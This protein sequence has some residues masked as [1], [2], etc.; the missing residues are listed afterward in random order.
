[1][2][3]IT[4]YFSKPVTLYV[5]QPYLADRQA[6]Q[7]RLNE[8]VAKPA[9]L[10]DEDGVLNPV[11]TDVDDLNDDYQ[12]RPGQLMAHIAKPHLQSNVLMAVM[13]SL[14]LTD[15]A[16]YIEVAGLKTITVDHFVVDEDDVYI[17]FKIVADASADMDLIAHKLDS[18]ISDGWGEDG[19]KEVPFDKDSLLDPGFFNIDSLTVD[20]AMFDI[21]HY[22]TL[23]PDLRAI[24]YQD[25]YMKALI[26]ALTYSPSQVSLR[27][28]FGYENLRAIED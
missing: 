5:S 7:S 26:R 6:I 9:G 17:I 20:G 18:Q 15:I 27:L 24:M 16:E 3:I 28:A 2:A 19:T 13:G 21:K 23:P 12:D 10:V 25:D 4:K 8:L 11:S 14:L 1:M 22:E